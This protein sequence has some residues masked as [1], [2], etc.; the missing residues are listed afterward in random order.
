[1]EKTSKGKLRSEE[2]IPRCENEDHDEEEPCA[3]AR[4]RTRVVG[5]EGTIPERNFGLPV[6]KTSG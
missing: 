2:T 6:E 5:F 4:A 3:S 1:M